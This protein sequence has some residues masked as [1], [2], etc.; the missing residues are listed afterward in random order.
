MPDLD[1]R[2]QP[3]PASPEVLINLLHD[4]GT[5]SFAEVSADAVRLA[6]DD[7]S[8]HHI[9]LHNMDFSFAE[10][11]GFASL[12][13]NDAEVHFGGHRWRPTYP[14]D[15]PK[16]P[17]FAATFEAMAAV[18]RTTLDAD[19]GRAEALQV[20]FDPREET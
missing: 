14:G 10:R 5:M 13:P 17:D 1:D 18:E 12:F 11:M 9:M 15:R 7:F 8:V 19:V 20:G 2:A 6:K 3:L 16:L 4:H